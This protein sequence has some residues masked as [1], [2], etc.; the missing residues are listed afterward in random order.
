MFNNLTAL[1][2]G[3]V[4]FAI[5]VG[6]GIV[7][8]HN[9]TGSIGCDTGYTWN[10]T[11]ANC[12]ETAN[13]SHSVAYNSKGDIITNLSTQLGTSGLAGWTAAII[14]LAVGLLF[15]GALMGKKKY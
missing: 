9:F 11:G 7:V 4:T 3:I 12:Y 6:V 15:I 10:S 1:A 14:A 5:V 13:T 2:L 8:L